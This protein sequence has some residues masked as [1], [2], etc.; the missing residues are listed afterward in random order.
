MEY[1]KKFKFKKNDRDIELE[2]FW[3]YR[4]DLFINKIKIENKEFDLRINKCQ[5]MKNDAYGDI[6]RI[7]TNIKNKEVENFVKELTGKE[8]EENSLYLIIP[9]DLRISLDD[10]I[11]NYCSYGA[12]IFLLKNLK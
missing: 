10:Y 8:F 2:V 6:L 9:N 12:R 5:L 4:H 11:E 7:D 3:G 1:I